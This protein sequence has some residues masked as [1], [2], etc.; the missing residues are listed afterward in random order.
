MNIAILE[1][2]KDR[3]QAMRSCLT[4]RFHQY[5]LRF[6]DDA[7]DLIDFLDTHLGETIVLCLDHDLELKSNGS[8]KSVDPGTGRDVADYLAKKPPVCPVVIHTT[9]GPAAVG[10][11]MVLKDANWKTHVVTPFDDMAWIPTVWFRTVRRAILNTARP[12]AN[13][14]V[15]PGMSKRTRNSLPGA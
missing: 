5:G 3:Q 7:A 10:M 15:A 13:G 8:G 14:A 1:D 12:A 11:E 2:N 4:D 6:F 9:N